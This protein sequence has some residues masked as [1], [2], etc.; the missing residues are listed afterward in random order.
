MDLIK[1]A[2][3][4][5]AALRRIASWRT[6]AVVISG[7]GVVIAWFGIYKSNGVYITA[8]VLL[9][10]A[11][12]FIAMTLHR[13]ITNGRRNVERILD[14]VEREKKKAKECNVIQLS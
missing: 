3:M 1:E 6:I 9:A 5:T 12:M 10:V 4:Q 2:Q 7:I 11:A 8:G 13:G 14:A